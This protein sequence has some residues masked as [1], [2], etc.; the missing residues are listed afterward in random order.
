M[1]D[2]RTDPAKPYTSAMPNSRIAEANAPS[3][4]YFSDASWLS[5]RRRLARPVSRYS[6][7]ENTSSATNKV[8]RSPAAG[9]IIMPPRASSTSGK[10]SVWV[11]PRAVASRS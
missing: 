6:G 5:S 1:A 7:S 10:T 2:S 11:S 8:S 4:K 3:R 9:K